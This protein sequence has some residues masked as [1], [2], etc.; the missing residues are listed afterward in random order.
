MQ[1]NQSFSLQ[2]LEAETQGRY[3][4]IKF[5]GRG[6]N[7]I[8]FEAIDK[9]TNQHVAVKR[10]ERL[11]ESTLDAKRTLREIR[12]LTH[13]RHEN[14]TNL[15]NVTTL[16]SFENFRVIIMVIDLME[17]DMFKIISSPQ[18][19]IVDHW[20]YFI[21]QLLRGLKYLHSANIL[22]RDLKPSNLLLNANCDLKICDFG[23]AR[24]SD[25]SNGFEYLTEYVATRW[26]RAPEVLLNYDK[27]GFAMD[28]W[29][30]GC[31]LA[32]LILR[33]ALFPGKG[34]MNQLALIADTI[35][36]PTEE[37]LVDCTNPKARQFMQSLPFKP[38][39]PFGLL[40]PGLDP[41]I[42]DILEK[43]LTWNPKKR[44]TV[45]E[46]LEH[47]FLQQ[48]HDPFDEPVT[49]PLDE[50]EFESSDLTLHD[51]KVLLWNEVLKFHPE[52]KQ[53]SG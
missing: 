37:D 45:E 12:I 49:F 32:E 17:T 44:I 6:A 46:A 42:V 23:L 20:K 15:H 34:T 21:Y 16:P 41:V 43:M 19:L 31:I 29:S 3:H 35:G 53:V 7:G 22:H 36:S 13:L 4:F 1:N 11:F 28:M 5:L 9:V 51:L 2:Q 25:P 38:K 47:P 39:V 50:F 33:R 27:Y 10:I 48:L 14:I 26:Y 52:F 40:F 8:V 24:V 18:P 30:V